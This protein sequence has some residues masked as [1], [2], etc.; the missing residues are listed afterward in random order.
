MEMGGHVLRSF[1][2][3]TRDAVVYLGR[4]DGGEAEADGGD[5]GDEGFEELAER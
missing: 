4:L 1:D 3:E 2:Q 5:G